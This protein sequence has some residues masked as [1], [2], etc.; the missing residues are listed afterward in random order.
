MYVTPC[1]C[2]GRGLPAPATS[3]SSDFLESPFGPFFDGV[4]MP[5]KT[6]ISQNTWE[7]LFHGNGEEEPLSQ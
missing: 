6:G 3:S 2:H 1:V 4:F 7:P 5:L